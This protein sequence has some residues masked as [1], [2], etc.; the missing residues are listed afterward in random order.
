MRKGKTFSPLL[1]CLFWGLS[2]LFLP[3]CAGKTQLSERSVRIVLED[4][5]G[6]APETA[7]IDTSAGSDITVSLHPGDGWTVTGC[8]YDG[9]ELVSSEDG[10]VL[11]T[12]PGVR[13]TQTVRILAELDPYVIRY[14]LDGASDPEAVLTLSSPATHLRVNTAAGELPALSGTSSDTAAGGSFTDPSDISSGRRRVP[15]LSGDG[16]RLL[17]G[18]TTEP[19]GA[20]T[21]IGLGSRTEVSGDLPLDLYADW[22]SFSD[23]A[24][25]AFEVT[26]GGEAVITGYT[27]RDTDLVIPAYMDGHPVTSIAE[28]A[29]SGAAFR[30]VV[31]PPTLREVGLY[32][33]ENSALTSLTFFDSLH[34]ITDY[35]FSGC[36]QL[37]TIRIQAVRDPVYS[38]TYFD[39]FCDKMDRLRLL[40]DRR[41]I[42]LFSGSSTRFG[43]DCAMIDEAFPDYEVQNLGVF[44]Y[45][46][47]LP[48]LDLILRFSGKGDILVHSPEFDAAARQFC[49]T[50][51]MDAAFFSMIEADYDLL[52]LLNYQDYG[53]LLSAFTTYQKEREGMG[54]GDYR[55]SA[56]SYDEDRHPVST[57]SYD[58]Y[59]D[60]ILPR[61]NAADDTPIYDLPVDYTAGS[62]S[63]DR[64]IRPLNA[65]Y[66]RFLDKGVRVYFTYAPR[67]REAVSE[68]STEEA[69]H[70]LDAW[71]RETLCVPVISDIETSLYPGRYLYGTDNHLSTEGVR[72]RTGQFLRDL[73]AQLD[74]EGTE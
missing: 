47:A 14:H 38:G 29:F 73:Q 54:S 24:S 71:F 5:P 49:C 4:V 52:A 69:R 53:G 27:G 40:K 50:N 26:P 19:G 2:A 65:V 25:F 15:L 61:P 36:A 9:A 32:A 6:V 12:L 13:Y 10:T 45:T 34:N 67:N 22:R 21:Q 51:A 8:D 70:E 46:N 3:A 20:G 64:F 35:A 17:C 18:W 31:L 59:G 66:Q 74:K 11:L 41:K 72:L 57:P 30:S 58:I 16:T 62:F 56:S 1:L 68:K 37:R 33:F 28:R 23:E 39:T 43:Y 42:L 55:L 60:Y 7:V 44:A 48:Q 63:T